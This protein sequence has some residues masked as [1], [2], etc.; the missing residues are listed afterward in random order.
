M[1]LIIILSVF[2][3]VNGHSQA[4]QVQS[5][6]NPLRAFFDTRLSS[7]PDAIPPP[8]EKLLEVVDAIKSVDQSSIN[9]ALP[10]INSA[11][12]SKI[13]NL[14]IEAIFALYE[15]SRRPDAGQILV[16][17][18]PLLMNM[19]TSTDERARNGSAVTIRTLSQQIPGQTIYLM[20]SVLSQSRYSQGVK[21]E[22]FRA[23]LDSKL[24]TDPD[25]TRSLESYIDSSTDVD[26]VRETLYAIA[27]GRYASPGSIDLALR[28][29]NS[30]N[31]SLQ[32]SAVQALY[33][34]GSEARSKAQPVFARLATD[35]TKSDS[36]RYI[37]DQALRGTL[38]QPGKLPE[39][40]S[41][42]RLQG[43]P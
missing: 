38:A 10:A 31:E 35:L 8:Y 33:A 20:S 37:A 34:M 17:D 4:A 11:A 19:L 23:I 32:I 27:A 14:A 1:R 7:K 42:P 39:A 13:P 25:I 28:S 15:I 3:F 30:S 12:L 36:L 24:R 5:E 2:F 43:L 6:K 21:S 26:F 16:G 22:M 40:K 18:I 41:A 29:L 9:A